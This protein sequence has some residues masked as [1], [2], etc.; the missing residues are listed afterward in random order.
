MLLFFFKNSI[1]RKICESFIDIFLLGMQKCSCQWHIMYKYVLWNG[2]LALRRM[3]THHQ[4]GYNVVINV[5][6]KMVIDLK[7]WLYNCQLWF[8]FFINTYESFPLFHSDS[9][10][11][12]KKSWWCP[13]DFYIH[14]H[15]AVGLK[16]LA[17]IKQKVK[18]D[19]CSRED[20]TGQS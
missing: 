11:D 16:D 14:A 9:R 15:C 13:C 3:D 7:R 4:N 5:K 17:L 8:F 6:G 19:V 2:W 10:H 18:K 1:F 20:C 12:G